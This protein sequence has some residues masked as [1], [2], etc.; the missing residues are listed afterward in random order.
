MDKYKLY[1]ELKATLRELEMTE[2]EY[3]DAIILITTL[4]E[5]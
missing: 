2:R 3:L 4:L 1:E 5:I